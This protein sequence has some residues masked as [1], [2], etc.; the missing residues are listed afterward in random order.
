MSALPRCLV[1]C[2]LGWS[3]ATSH[4]H[5]D[6]ATEAR[7][8]FERGLAEADATHWTQAAELFQQALALRDSPVIRYNLGSALAELGRLVEARDLLRALELDQRSSAELLQRV[9]PQREAIERRLSNLTIRVQTSTPDWHV[10]LDERE[11]S[12]DQLGVAL[13][14]DPKLHY[15]SLRAGER[16]LDDAQVELGEGEARELK[17]AGEI[18]PPVVVAP[19][20]SPLEISLVGFAHEE[21]QDAP[22][23]K[24]KR[25]LLWGV[26]AAA[27]AV[28]AGVVAGVVIARKDDADVPANGFTPGRVGVRVPQ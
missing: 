5:A 27:A 23:S 2:L 7:A 8:L 10:L 21:H 11:L 19:P 15:V 9:T 18:P 17:L 20:P 4:A 22:S 24:R 16:V 28:V 6:A 13:P 3:L 12:R 26:S 25:R 1:V 14:L